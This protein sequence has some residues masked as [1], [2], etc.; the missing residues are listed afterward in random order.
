MID[1]CSLHNT[2]ILKVSS[3]K[4]QPMFLLT[5][6]IHTYWKQNI[7][8]SEENFLSSPLEF[9]WKDICYK[10][11]FSEY[12]SCRMTLLTKNVF[13]ALNEVAGDHCDIVTSLPRRTWIWVLLFRS[14]FRGAVT[15]HF[16]RQSQSVCHSLIIGPMND[17]RHKRIRTNSFSRE[18]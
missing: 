13:S 11:I 6:E 4:K 5:P 8:Y 16:S 3:Y 15:S 10:N 18:L 7:S 9:K 2:E 1:G 12:R 17:T 14:S